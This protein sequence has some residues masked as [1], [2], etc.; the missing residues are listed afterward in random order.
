MPDGDAGCG[1]AADRN[2][3]AMWEPSP[4]LPRIIGGCQPSGVLQL[5]GHPASRVFLG[6]PVAKQGA[7]GAAPKRETRTIMHR[8]TTFAATI[9][10][11]TA[12][13]GVPADLCGQ[14]RWS[15]GLEAESDP[16]LYL[17]RVTGIA[18]DSRLRA[19]VVDPVSERIR[20]LDDDLT[21]QQ[22][23]GRRGRGPGEF[24]WPATIQI[25]E[26]DSLYV[27]DGSLARV[28]VF[29]PQDLTVAYTVTLP[30]LRSTRALWRIPEQGGYIGVRSPPISAR[31]TERDDRDRFDLVFSLDEEGETESDSIY[32]LPSAEL[33]IVR[34]ERGVMVGPH[35]PYG[36]EPFLGLLGDDRLVYANSRSPS[37]MILDLA[38]AVHHSF[39]VPATEVSVSAADLE[40]RIESEEIE[41]FARALEQDAPYMWPALTGL[42][43]DDRQRIW[44]GTRSESMR[45]EREWIAFTQEGGQ[46]GS[47]LLPAPFELHAV[48]GD[49]LFGVV[50][51]EFDV[52]QIQVY[53]LED[54]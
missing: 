3:G 53:R 43:V 9:A 12:F 42:V 37:L 23:V 34:R 21:L 10:V 8:I 26:D 24:E 52:P 49:R 5:L 30:H 44:I 35:H 31:Q 2:P 51:D 39:G 15:A 19:Y 50:T 27:F 25:L 17:V 22:E 18:I 46:V 40:A 28:T 16:N 11:G 29:E 6:R 45:D 4:A 13:L 32:A 20:I 1:R 41:P 47:V 7:R 38:G 54:E 36:G 33:L 48:R 14:Q